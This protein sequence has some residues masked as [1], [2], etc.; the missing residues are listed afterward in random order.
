MDL[1]GNPQLNQAPP[2]FSMLVDWKNA[3]QKAALTARWA[4]T[5]A[6][7]RIRQVASRTRWQVVTFY[8]KSGGESV[9]LV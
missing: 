9:G 7:V 5:M 3:Q 6:N 1:S 4:V 8:G 2:A